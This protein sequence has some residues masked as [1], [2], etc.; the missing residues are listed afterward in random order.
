MAC[1]VGTKLRLAGEAYEIVF[2]YHVDEAGY[3]AGAHQDL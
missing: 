2:G 1:H 3:K